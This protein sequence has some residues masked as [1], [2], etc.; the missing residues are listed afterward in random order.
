MENI[1]LLFVC[2]FLGF[3]FQKIPQ[4][5]KNSHHILNQYVIHISIPALAL[6][7]IPKIELS[8]ALLYPLGVA[9]IGFLLSFLFFYTL[10]NYFKWSKKLTGC[11]ILTAGL[12]NTS[13]V[14]FPLIEAMFGE[15]GLKTAII[16]DQPSSFVVVATLGILVATLFSS[17]TTSVK[18]IASKVFYF[19]PF[20]F[21]MLALL[22]ALI[23]FDFPPML[24]HVFFR[25]GN[26]VTPIAL[27]AVGLQL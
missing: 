3:L 20:I 24:Q 13:F 17:S 7:Y 8:V 23:R 22:C 21:F 19:P 26:T 14:G 6:Y 2:L 12:G 9:W 10:G 15:K 1:I 27:V 4:F 5:P 25:L 18:A 11:L 16:V